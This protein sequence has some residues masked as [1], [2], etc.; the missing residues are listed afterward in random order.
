MHN[1]YALDEPLSNPADDLLGMDIYAQRLAEFIRDLTPP[2]TIGVYGEWG[3]G[4]TTFVRFAK[5]YLVN[6]LT[7][8]SRQEIKFIDFTAWP[9]TTSDELWRALI[10][11]IAKALYNV[12]DSHNSGPPTETSQP[13]QGFRAFLFNLL[14]SSAISP[15]HQPEL[16]D[17]EKIVAQLEGT[18][19]GSI[20]K[21]KSYHI[22]VN[23]EEAILAT[24]NAVLTAL[25]TISP[26]IGGL[27]QFFGSTFDV[28]ISSQMRQEKNEAIRERIQGIGAFQQLIKKMFEEKAG[29]KQVCVFIDDL[30]RCMPDVALE[31]LEAIKV[32]LGNVPC[33][34]IVAVDEQLIGQGL[35]LR[36]QALLQAD[37]LL[38]TQSFFAKKGQEYFEKIIQLSI[39][40]PSRTE[41]QV[42]TFIGSQYPLWNP[43]TDI[44]YSAIGDNARRL[45][46]YCDWLN[47]QNSVEIATTVNGME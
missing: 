24:A 14:T 38:D 32:L 35:K 45:K 42:H 6:D 17:Y 23:Q 47:Y 21:D 34:F 19:V 37:N 4:K 20:R 1:K 5:H 28:D 44:I 2:F 15:Q 8:P 39:R 41:A 10:M 33:I 30:D 18:I 11:S 22:Q 3:S 27:R 16:T 9:H 46:Q 29:N 25:G 40:I 7:D 36:F 31:L 13:D 12:S 26:I 43:V